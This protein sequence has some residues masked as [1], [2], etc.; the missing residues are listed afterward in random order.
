MEARAAKRSDRFL[1]TAFKWQTSTPF[2][3][4]NSAGFSQDRQ[5]EPFCVCSDHRS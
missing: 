3:H 4:F 1:P 5:Q 2:S